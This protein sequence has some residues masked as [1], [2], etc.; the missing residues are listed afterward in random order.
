MKIVVLAAVAALALTGAASAAQLYRWVDEKGRVE[1]RDT[2]PPADAKNV[3]QR[4][5]GG[6]TIQTS[7]LPYGVQQAIKKNPVTL[8]V[9]DCGEPCTTARNHLVRRGVP[10][11][12]RNASRESEALKKLT[13]SLEVPVLAVGSKTIKGYL[14]TDWDAAL[15]GAGYPR[16]AMPGMKGEAQPVQKPQT[17]AGKPEAAKPTTAKP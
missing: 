2:P 14:E 1:W 16:T 10:Y 17:P 12:E 3:E 9:F 11:T 5:M 6:N 15:D 4:S 7:T 8:W 13:G